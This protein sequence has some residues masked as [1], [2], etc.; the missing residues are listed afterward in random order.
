MGFPFNL[1]GL[2]PFIHQDSNL[3]R[4]IPDGR[5]CIMLGEHGFHE[6]IVDAIKFLAMTPRLP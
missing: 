4:V 3:L 6:F 5:L 2:F 1:A